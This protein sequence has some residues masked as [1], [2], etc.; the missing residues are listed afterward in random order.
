MHGVDVAIERELAHRFVE[1]GDEL[2]VL[3][4]QVRRSGERILAEVVHGLTG[5]SGCRRTGRRPCAG[6]S[7]P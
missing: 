7:T 1:A 4:G 6:E 5:R 2:R 3:H